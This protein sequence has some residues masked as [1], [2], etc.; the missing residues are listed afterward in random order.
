MLTGVNGF[1]SCNL[2]H[3]LVSY[4]HQVNIW[5]QITSCVHDDPKDANVRGSLVF[6]S[7]PKN[8]ARSKMTKVNLADQLCVGHIW[9]ISI[10][11]WSDLTNTNTFSSVRFD[12]YEWLGQI[13]PISTMAFVGFWPNQGHLSTCAWSSEVK[14]EITLGSHYKGSLIASIWFDTVALSLLLL[15]MFSMLF[16]LEIKCCCSWC[17]DCTWL[18][19]CVGWNYNGSSS[20][21]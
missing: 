17:F 20:G 16:S 11:P 14:E 1:I 9:P 2:N 12:Q 7:W 10:M 15:L 19:L 6:I 4:D 21:Q 13:R 18:S 3:C 5:I 8:L